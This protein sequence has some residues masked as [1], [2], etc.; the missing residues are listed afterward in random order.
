MADDG[1]TGQSA[2][3]TGGAGFIGSH[4]TDAL[5]ADNDVTVVDDLSNGRRD[6]VP[7]DAT[8]VEA[9]VADRDDLSD[10]M[11]DADVVFHQ[12]AQV[13]VDR[14]VE[15]PVASHETN[16]DATLALLELA[17]EHD[18]RVVLASSCA[19]YGQPESVPLS[20]SDLLDPTSPYGLEKLTV[21]HYAR[22]YHDLYDLE[23]VAL[24]YFNVYGPGQAGGDYSGVISVFLEKAAAGDP[25]T[26][27]GDGTQ[28]RDFVHVEDVVRANLLAATTDHV[29]E[30]Y[31]VGTG[32]SISI[33]DLAELVLDLTGTDAEIVHTDARPGDIQHSR[34]D[35]SKARERLGYD[36]TVAFR[37]GLDGTADWHR[38]RRE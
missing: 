16:V 15:A 37:D 34:A 14:S 13:S 31:N 35:V 38:T 26:V 12:A 19:V 20:E 5:V 25:I 18:V 24:R 36:P 10:L 27:H 1:P 22:L 28:T 11:A 17:R 30:A 8:F 6:R 21:D 9:D 32:E 23:T 29:G 4:L 2:L 3:V 33:R 7:D